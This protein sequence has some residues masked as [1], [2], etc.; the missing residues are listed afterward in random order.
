MAIVAILALA[1]VS[2]WMFQSIYRLYFHPLSKIPGPK[3]AAISYGYEVYY[4][5]MKRGRFIWE[6]ERWHE[7]YGPIVRINPREVHIKDPDY[8]DEI[9]ASSARPR[10]KD[11]VA[12][13]QF[14]VEGSGFAAVDAETHRQRRAPVEK[15]FS[16]RAIAKQEGWIWAGLEK[17]GRHLE[18]AGRSQRPVSLDAAF[19]L[20]SQKKDLYERAVDALK[21]A[22][23]QGPGTA[24]IDGLAAATM[25]EH[26]RSPHRLMNEG[27]ALIVGGTETIARALSLAAYHL[28]TREEIRHKL[29]EELKQVMPRP[30]ARPTWNA[31]EKLPYLSG[32][33]SETLRLSTGIGARS[34]RVAPTEALVYQNYTIPPGTPVSETNYFVLMDPDIFPDPHA[35]DPDRWTRA[36]ANG[37]RLDRY[38]VSFSKGSRMCVAVNLAYAELF[39]AIATLVRRFDL[40][41]YDTPQSNLD[42]VREFATPHPDQGS[43]SV[44]ARITG[45]IRE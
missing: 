41:L 10:E 30:D 39:L 5:L 43:W 3:L 31:L 16:K 32:V 24:V 11:P 12:L 42:F 21:R 22:D 45:V 15:F 1:S 35:F 38:L 4:N 14:R 29:R 40:Q 37:H 36:A 27:L 28:F 2:Y 8:Y 19:A 20:A 7:I 17:M 9:Y 23:P 18:T 33:I 6:V 34:P 44:R 13:A 26:L 25:A